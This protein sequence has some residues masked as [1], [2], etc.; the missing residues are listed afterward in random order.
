MFRK[1]YPCACKGRNHAGGE[2]LDN[3]VDMTII[4][5]SPGRDRI[6]SSD[7]KCP[8]NTGGH[9]QRCK[10]AHLYTDKVEGQEAYC[11]YSF[12]L[13]YAEISLAYKKPRRTLANRDLAK[14]AMEKGNP[15]REYRHLFVKNR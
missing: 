6:V 12:D 15:L 4:I 13:P 2:V 5:S 14:I 11:P 3:P 8:Y 10:A 7:V 1:E 9:G